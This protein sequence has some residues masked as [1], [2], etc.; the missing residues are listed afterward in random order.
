MTKPI[1]GPIRPDIL[2]KRTPLE[3]LATAAPPPKTEETKP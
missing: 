3:R 2:T 1:P